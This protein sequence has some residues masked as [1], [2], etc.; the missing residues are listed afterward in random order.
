METTNK[1]NEI[2]L[3]LKVSLTRTNEA[4][5]LYHNSG[6]KF[7]FA[8]RIYK[9]NIKIYEILE[10]FLVCCDESQF[11]DVINYIFHLDDWFFQFEQLKK[12]NPKIDDEFVF[13]RASGAIPYPSKFVKYLNELS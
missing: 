2:L 4:Y 7:L 5:K 11:Q 12:S 8:M 1:N 9:A 13:E 3:K 6:R 10:D